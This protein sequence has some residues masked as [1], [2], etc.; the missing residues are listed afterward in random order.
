MSRSLLFLFLLLSVSVPAAYA[1]RGV[2][3]VAPN[4]QVEFSPGNLQY[5]PKTG[6]W[7]FAKHQWQTAGTDNRQ[8]TKTTDCKAYVDLFGWATSGYDNT[9][10]DSLAFH[11]HPWDWFCELEDAVDYYHNQYAY[12]PTITQPDPDLV[13]SSARYDWGVNNKIHGCGKTTG[14]RV[15]SRSEWKYLLYLRPNARRLHRL[16]TV[17]GVRGLLLL[18]DNGDERHAAFLPFTGTRYGSAVVDLDNIGCYWTSTCHNE[19]SAYFLSVNLH[20][21]GLSTELY[22]RHTGRAVRLVRDL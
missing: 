21:V 16:T 5:C 14:W 9:A 8:I 15:L 19:G 7:R 12:G 11:F 17:H 2:F 3:S 13:G 20:Y 18:P 10:N 22:G 4:R 1:A 6:R